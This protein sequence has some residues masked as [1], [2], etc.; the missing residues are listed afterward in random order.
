M[1]SG[2]GRGGCSNRILHGCCQE[3]GEKLYPYPTPVLSGK[4]GWEGLP[5]SYTGVVGKKEGGALPVSYACAV[6]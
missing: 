6:E 3:N 4:G 2:K 1:L 5:V